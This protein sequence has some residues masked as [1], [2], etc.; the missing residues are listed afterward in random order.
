MKHFALVFAVVLFVAVAGLFL[1][2]DS[3]TGQ[4][5]LYGQDYGPEGQP[6]LNNRQSWQW[7]TQSPERLSDRGPSK[8]VCCDA[9]K[10]A[11]AGLHKCPSTRSLVEKVCRVSDE[12]AEEGRD[13]YADG[14]LFPPCPPN[15][16]H[17]PLPEK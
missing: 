2:R 16:E 9:V 6:V 12:I 13:N 17:C 4:S 8:Y 3:L 11:E 10:I 5:F 1:S 15:N 7:G 14:F